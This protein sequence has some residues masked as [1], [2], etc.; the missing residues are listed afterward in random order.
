MRERDA[1]QSD[2]CLSAGPEELIGANRAH[3]KEDQR[4]RADKF[5]YKFLRLVIHGDASEEKCK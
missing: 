4:K 3:A 5:S 2:A 1:Q